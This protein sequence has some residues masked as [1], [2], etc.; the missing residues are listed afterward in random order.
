MKRNPTGISKTKTNQENALR[1]HT[2]HTTLFLALAMLLTTL[3]PRAH[4]QNCSAATV[5]GKWSLTLTGTL[6][7]PTGPAPAAAV[8]NATLTPNGTVLG[9]EG[10]N[11]GGDY[12]HETFKGRYAVNANCTGITTVE[13]FEAGQLVRTSVLTIMF[14]DNSN[15]VR[16]V[17]Q[18]LTLPDGTQVPVV[19][20]VE[21]RKY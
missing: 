3:A 9:T 15:E 18:S 11:V 14:D 10:R 6:L 21:G 20:T 19:I 16:M 1:P 17:Q 5:A 4:A 8:I 13:F 12:A 2:A 7:L